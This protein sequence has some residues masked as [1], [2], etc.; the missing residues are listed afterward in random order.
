MYGQLVCLTTALDSLYGFVYYLNMYIARYICTPAFIYEYLCTSITTWSTYI[1]MIALIWL[2]YLYQHV[3]IHIFCIDLSSRSGYI[4]L[5]YVCF[6]QY[7]YHFF[8]TYWY[9]HA[10]CT[11]LST[12]NWIC[13]RYMQLSGGT[14]SSLEVG[15]QQMKLILILL[16]LNIFHFCSGILSICWKDI[17]LMYTCLS[18]NLRNSQPNLWWFKSRFLK[19]ILPLRRIQCQGHDQLLDRICV[20]KTRDLVDGLPPGL[21]DLCFFLW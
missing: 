10:L 21:W 6:H 9:L 1:P 16:V 3:F 5:N 14:E 4:I 11:P 18:I 20:S 15:L 13:S 19:T 8:Y 17:G 7:S 12:S 2:I